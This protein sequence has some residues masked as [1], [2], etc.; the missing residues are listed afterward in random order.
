LRKS[1]HWYA[2]TGK[3]FARD[4]RNAF[5][6]SRNLKPKNRGLRLAP[7]EAEVKSGRKTVMLEATKTVRE[8]A[9]EI[10]SATRV[11]EALKIDY[12]CG[13][14]RPLTEACGEN[15]LDLKE[16]LQLLEQAG[17]SA[18]EA[19]TQPAFRHAQADPQSMSLA[20]L[21]N[22]IVEKHHTYTRQEL[23]RLTALLEKVCAAHGAN[24]SELLDIR[25][26]FQILRA[27]LEPHMLKEERILFPYITRLETAVG[28]KQ[29]APF[30]PFGEVAN[31]IMVMM[32]EHDSAGE[33]LKTMRELS[34]DFRPPD[35]GCFS[36]RTLYNVL[37]ELEADLHQHIHLENNILFP[38]SLEMEQKAAGKM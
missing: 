5:D 31:P 4:F 6:F 35:D 12:C 22:V 30:A 18:T 7:S 2:Q 20:S 38:R 3:Y 28:Q 25:S 19:E 14:N 13:G 9:I 37:A 15:G 10:P 36:Y 8:F 24:H 17:R 27:E 11:F 23:E 29:P 1:T 32:R 34:N 21:I 33:I 26:H 16:V